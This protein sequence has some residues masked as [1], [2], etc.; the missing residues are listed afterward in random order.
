MFGRN[1]DFVGADRQSHKRKRG[2]NRLAGVW[3]SITVHGFMGGKIHTRTFSS[4]G[5]KGMEEEK[6]GLSFVVRFVI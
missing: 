5:R 4:E 2:R 3:L 6:V 1:W